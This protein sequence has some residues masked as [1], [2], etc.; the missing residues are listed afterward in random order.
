VAEAIL[1]G[2]KALGGGALVPFGSFGEILLDGTTFA[3][4]RTDLELGPH[5]ATGGGL[6]QLDGTDRFRRQFEGFGGRSS[7]DGVRD[8]AGGFFRRFA[9]RDRI[10][11]RLG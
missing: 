1:R 2:R 4:D 9:R 5:V 10:G 11:D 8:A 3:E 7:G 6:A